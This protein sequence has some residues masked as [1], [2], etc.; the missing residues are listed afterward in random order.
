TRAFEGGTMSRRNTFLRSIRGGAAAALLLLPAAAAP[1]GAAAPETKRQSAPV[2]AQPEGRPAAEV[3]PAWIDFA[4]ERAEPVSVSWNPRTGTPQSLFGRLAEAAPGEAPEASA[5]RFLAENARLFRLPPALQGLA[6]AS[7]IES[8]MGRHLTF[9]QAYRGVHVFGA[10]VK[11]HFNGAGEIVALNNTSVPDIALAT[12][13]PALRARQAVR[14]ALGAVPAAEEPEEAETP[15]AQ[16]V[17]HAEGEAP[18]LAWEVTIATGGPTWRVFVDAESGD[19]LTAPEDI[20]RYAN[21]TGRVFNVNAVVATHDNTLRDQNDA[22]SAVPGS[23]YSIVPLQGLAG[24]GLLDGAFASSSRT[25][26]RVSS[27]TN[28]FVFDRSSDGFSETMG[29]YYTDYAERY[30]QSLGFAN[31]NNRQQVFSV[32]KLRADNSFYSPQTK[33]IT[34]GLGGVDDAEDA[35]VIWHEYGHSIQDNQVPGFGSSLEGGSMGEGFGDYWAGSVGAQF[36]GGFQDTCVAE[37]DATSYSSS[38]PPCLRRLDSTKHYPESVVGQVHADGE[39]WSAALW[40]IRGAIG[41]A[42][43]DKVVLQ[44]HFL[45]TA[46]ASFNQGANALVTAAINLGYTTKEVSAIRTILQ[47]RG[48]T[49]TVP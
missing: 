1:A 27:A 37:W 30:I 6:L 46:N 25:R 11:V 19:L 29:Y 7:D 4:A 14:I 38:N 21:G 34:Y 20:N 31:V 44:A 5:R 22:A 18:V 24:N 33:E 15:S 42:K 35:E 13:R 43:A 3:L 28:T 2:A 41:A 49:V 10:E 23:A 45:L 39:I 12:V 16:L 48:F 9:R 17:V 40:Q 36:S 47:N 8:P 26:K 32:N